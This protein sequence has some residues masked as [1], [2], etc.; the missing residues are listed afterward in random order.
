VP[1]K[2]SNRA[3]KPA[4]PEPIG[5]EIKMTKRNMVVIVMIIAIVCTAV[6]AKKHE[7]KITLPE[8]VKAA[9]KALYP[10][11]K[12]EKTRMEKKGLKLYEVKLDANGTEVEVMADADGTVASVETKEKIDGLP[13]AVAKAAASKG[14]KVV[15][16]EKKVVHARLKL[17]KLDTPETK[18]EVKV[19]KKGKTIELK[20]AADGKI[21]KEEEESKEKKE[22]KGDDNKD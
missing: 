7:G 22:H 3:F 8:A 17:I 14:G 19:E 16:A 21:L 4:V 9:I 12:I 2:T 10:A 18:Y 1:I 5:K 15:D 20:I 6:Y 11:G 13:A